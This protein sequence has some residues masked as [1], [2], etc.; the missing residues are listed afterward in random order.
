[1]LI[2]TRKDGES[3]KIEGN[4]EIKVI[5]T[6]KNGVK[7]GI[8][9]PKNVMILRSELINEIANSNLKASLVNKNSLN[10]LSKKFQK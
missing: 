9:A 8:E 3:I 5:Q 2:L 7:I 6:L 1:M 10:E 4:I